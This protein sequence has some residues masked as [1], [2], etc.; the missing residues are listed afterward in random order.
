MSAN[1]RFVAHTTKRHAHELATECT[2]DGPRERC[3][4]D[5]RRPHEAEDRAIQ[6]PD[7]LQHRDVIQDAVLHILET[8]MID[9]EDFLRPRDIE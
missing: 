6:L 2:R 9:V 3:L 1:F 8:V 7:L 5:T 4:A